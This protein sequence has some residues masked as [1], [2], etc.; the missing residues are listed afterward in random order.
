V[1]TPLD[2]ARFAPVAEPLQP[3]AQAALVD[4]PVKRITADEAA[5]LVGHALPAVGEFVLLRALVLE[6]GTG[7]FGVGV[8]GL[9]VLVRHDCLGQSPVPM[10]RRALVAVL[11]AVPESVFVS[12]SMAE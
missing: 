3:E 11:P 10:H 2:E 7:A 1:F 12:C 4:A 6:E 8:S 5:R 9:A